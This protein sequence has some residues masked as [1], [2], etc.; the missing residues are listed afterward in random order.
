M[1][2]LLVL[3][4][5]L[6]LASAANAVLSISVNGGDP[7]AEITIFPFD[8]LVLDISS[9][10]SVSYGVWLY[11]YDGNRTLSNPT[12]PP[13]VGDISSYLGGHYTNY[14]YYYV[15]IADSGGNVV[16]GTGFEVDY[17]ATGIDDILIELYDQSGVTVIDSLVIHQTPEPMTIA[18]L[19]LGGLLLRRRR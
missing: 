13:G 16:P 9:D 14:N 18:L 6:G 17:Q 12:Q 15:T 19:G 2:K 11:I 5:V 4:L 1:K 7:G 10:N 3:M 8:S